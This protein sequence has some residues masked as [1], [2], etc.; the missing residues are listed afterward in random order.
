[1]LGIRPES[2][3][4]SVIGLASQTEPAAAGPARQKAIQVIGPLQGT[5]DDFQDAGGDTFTIHSPEEAVQLPGGSEFN[6]V[7]EAYT[8]GAHED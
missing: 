6:G 8:R 2:A 5:V 7:G 3:T 4:E 1:M